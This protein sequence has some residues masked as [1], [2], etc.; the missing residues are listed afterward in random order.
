M[1]PISL[2]AAAPLAEMGLIRSLGG[3]GSPRAKH[4]QLMS[5]LSHANQLSCVYLSPAPGKGGGGHGGRDSREALK[6]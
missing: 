4:S 2:A 5:A 3:T 1:S 6:I